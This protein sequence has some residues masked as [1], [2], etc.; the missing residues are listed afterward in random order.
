MKILKESLI[1]FGA[2]ATLMSLIWYAYNTGQ[3]LREDGTLSAAGW[4]ALCRQS[5]WVMDGAVLC[6]FISRFDDRNLFALVTPL[7]L[8]SWFLMLIVLSNYLFSGNFRFGMCLRCFTRS[9]QPARWALLITV[10]S[11]S[12]Y[13][14]LGFFPAFWGGRL[15]RGAR[16]H[17]LLSDWILAGILFVSL[18]LVTLTGGFRFSLLLFI[19]VL[20]TTVTGGKWRTAGI[21]TAISG[22][23]IL[24]YVLCDSFRLA[25]V[26]EAF[27]C[28]ANAIRA[29]PL[30]QTMLLNGGW[31]GIGI[32][33]STYRDWLPHREIPEILS[34]SV[35]EE[36][37]WINLVAMLV[38]IFLLLS[39]ALAIGIKTKNRFGRRLAVG[40][41]A[42]LGFQTLFHISTIM[43]WT[44][45]FLACVPLPFA[46]ETGFNACLPLIGLG[47][48]FSI[49]NHPEPDDSADSPVR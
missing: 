1:A 14:T 27:S 44:S 38:C 29:A 3:P 45:P 21:F 12:A 9:F 7:L 8:L 41:V 15:S 39:T 42:L 33:N 23:A 2:L 25:R 40:I 24:L 10:V 48:L 37:G 13:T 49:A 47:L 32:G 5:L 28:D 31:L 26:L 34:A 4:G 11:L 36:F 22:I 19:T 35:G 30:T 46:S 43:D 20:V 18:L 16:P 17:P 6:W